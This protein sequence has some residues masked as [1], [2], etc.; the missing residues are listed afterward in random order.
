MKRNLFF[1]SAHSR[2]RDRARHIREWNVIFL[3]WWYLFLNNLSQSQ[4][5]ILRTHESFR[6]SRIIVASGTL[7]SLKLPVSC[8]TSRLTPLMISLLADRLLSDSEV[9][10]S[11]FAFI[12]V[13]LF[14]TWLLF[15]SAL[16]DREIQ[17]KMWII[18]S[19]SSCCLLF[20]EILLVQLWLYLAMMWCRICTWGYHWRVNSVF[21]CLN[22][23]L[24]SLR[25]TFMD[26]VL[27]FN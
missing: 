10:I 15:Q 24:L 23:L 26:L 17:I 21:F 22:C 11:H 25:T 9:W 8:S 3:W 12:H 6:L 5:S 18:S 7:F 4:G 27:H 14:F 2:W 13:R 16:K 19:N 1:I 20:Y